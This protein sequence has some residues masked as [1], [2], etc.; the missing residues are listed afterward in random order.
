VPT[1]PSNTPKY[2]R[3][4]QQKVMGGLVYYKL[5]YNKSIMDE[6]ACNGANTE[7]FYPEI[8]QYTRVETKFYENLCKG[9]PIIKE[10]LEWGLAH[11]RSGVWGGTTPITRTTLRRKLKWGVTD[12]QTFTDSLIRA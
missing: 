7:M 4:I 10:C 6:G 5:R 9:C 2:H 8:G 1:K 11:E 3:V 12:P